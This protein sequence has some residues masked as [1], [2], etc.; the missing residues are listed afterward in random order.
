MQMIRMSLEYWT[1]VI[2]PKEKSCSPDRAVRGGNRGA[3]SIPTLTCIWPVFFGQPPHV[4]LSPSLAP[5]L[6]LAPEPWSSQCWFS[7]F[8][9]GP[10]SLL[11]LSHSSGLQAHFSL[12]TTF[13]VPLT[14]LTYLLSVFTKASF[15]L[16]IFLKFFL[17]FKSL[18]AKAYSLPIQSPDLAKNIL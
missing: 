9:A 12:Q 10:T 18:Q 5:V 7:V 8:P 1:K 6:S 17:V 2:L 11:C 15:F 16:L 14:F 3:G 4:F 13:L